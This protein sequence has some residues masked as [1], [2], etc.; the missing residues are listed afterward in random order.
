[1]HAYTQPNVW[2]KF[3]MGIIVVSLQIQLIWL[4]SWETTHFLYQ[5]FRLLNWTY[6]CII[7]VYIVVR[8]LLFLLYSFLCGVNNNII[9]STNLCAHIV[10]STGNTGSI[11]L[12]CVHYKHMLSHEGN[13]NMQQ[14][15]CMLLWLCSDY[16]VN[17]PKYYDKENIS[18]NKKE[19][20]RQEQGIK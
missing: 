1:M 2:Q 6:L 13:Y 16:L 12:E 9:I 17:D 14:H 18:S 3:C 11:C 20:E 10:A 19:I 15:H 7:C 4:K 8:Y 5:A